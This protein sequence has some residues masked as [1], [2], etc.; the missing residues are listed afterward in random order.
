MRT[1]PLFDTFH[2]FPLLLD[3]S[4]NKETD[5]ETVGAGTTKQRWTQRR[6][7]YKE[8]KEGR[9]G[10]LRALLSSDGR[11]GATSLAAT[12]DQHREWFSEVFHGRTAR[13]VPKLRRA[14]TNGFAIHR[15]IGI[16]VTD[17]TNGHRHQGKVLYCS[18]PSFGS[19]SSTARRLSH[20]IEQRIVWSGAHCIEQR[21]IA[22]N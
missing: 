2:A 3:D 16:E 17:G 21:S 9:I 7:H 19:F 22:S 1:P 5:E 20:R 14:W 4:A 11:R 12:I 15:D 10:K 8:G 13:A 18:T 6:R